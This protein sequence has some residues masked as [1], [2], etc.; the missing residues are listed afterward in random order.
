[1]T[2]SRASLENLVDHTVAPVLVDREK[3]LGAC[4]PLGQDIAVKMEWQ[5]IQRMGKE[6]HIPP[7]EQV[8]ENTVGVLA[9]DYFDCPAGNLVIIRRTDRA[10]IAFLLECLRV[11]VKTL[12]LQSTP[13]RLS[14]FGVY[15]T[16]TLGGSDNGNATFEE[17][18]KTA[19]EALST[20]A[21]A[22]PEPWGVITSAGIGL[23][24]AFF[25]DSRPNP[26]EQLEKSLIT[27]Q[28]HAD[29]SAI[30]MDAQAL[31][32]WINVELAAWKIAEERGGSN[33]LTEQIKKW[34]SKLDNFME[35]GRGTVW[36]DLQQ[37]Q[38]GNLSS[39]E[40]ALSVFVMTITA[41]LNGQKFA[42]ILDGLKASV[43]KAK[44][45]TVAFNQ[46][47][48]EWR[49]SYNALV[50]QVLGDKDDSIVG[51]TAL[52]DNWIAK[53][54]AERLSKISAVRK[55]DYAFPPQ[56]V[57][58]YGPPPLGH[59]ES[60]FEWRD[61][62]D[63]GLRSYFPDRHCNWTGADCTYQTYE[64]KANRE[65][66]EHLNIIGQQLDAKYKKLRE[67]VRG[68]QSTMFEWSNNMPPGPA[69]VAPIIDDKGWESGEAS[70]WKD[71][72]Q[73]QYA[74]A[75]GNKK[76]PGEIS[77][78]SN[79]ATISGI[80]PKVTIS[81]DQ[82]QQATKRWV[83]RQFDSDVTT[84]QCIFVMDNTTTDFVDGADT[85][86]VDWKLSKP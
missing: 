73:V 86:W 24:L 33:D 77:P 12:Q 70:P 5:L 8:L 35:G 23:I 15:A 51:F 75:F 48:I 13:N 29:L 3:M 43:A 21:F 11:D 74:I 45:D 44:G 36:N 27:F 58:K 66:D 62:A 32:N 16:T 84:L 20:L 41:F 30:A 1:M 68:W 28:K 2:L 80:N 31:T 17:C 46:A 81:V 19:L 61:D 78:W 22:L 42:I 47:V 71:H 14:R 50:I 54:I 64:E 37:I 53:R 34:E 39:E 52:I 79:K 9:V 85:N 10:T 18:T 69:K 82:M 49:I 57:S 38:S 6:W 26:F 65:H 67:I 83:Y 55:F 7:D 72:K 25:P 56:Y 63:G 59:I 60:A 4:S 40:A 76:G